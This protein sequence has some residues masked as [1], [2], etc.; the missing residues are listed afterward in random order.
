MTSRSQHAHTYTTTAALGDD[1]GTS[2]GGLGEI[3]IVI[4]DEA[5]QLLEP[6]SLLP[7]LAAG[8]ARRAILVRSL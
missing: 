4:M 3:P 2:N 7:L 5:S 6:I 8:G 1:T